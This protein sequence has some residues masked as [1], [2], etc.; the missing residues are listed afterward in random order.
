MYLPLYQNNYGG[1]GG[2]VGAKLAGYGS[3]C[4][5]PQ[6]FKVTV[7]SRRRIRQQETLYVKVTHNCGR[8]D[9]VRSWDVGKIIENNPGM[10]IRHDF[11][12]AILLYILCLRKQ[13]KLYELYQAAMMW[14]QTP[15]VEDNTVESDLQYLLRQRG[16]TYILTYLCYGAES[17]LRS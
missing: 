5:Q 13:V 7:A 10:V 1:G 6:S 4:Y 16:G 12:V 3:E 15:R 9:V 14:Y 11:W 2:H 8:V 17:F